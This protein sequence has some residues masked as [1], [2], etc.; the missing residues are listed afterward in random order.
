MNNPFGLIIPIIVG[1]VGLAVIFYSFVLA[2]KAAAKEA[3]GLQVVD[4]SMVLQKESV[5]MQKEGMELSRE[6]NRILKEILQTL[7][8]NG[9]A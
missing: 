1:G 3:K 5:A 7:K 9:A 6:S 8:D 4:E 2:K